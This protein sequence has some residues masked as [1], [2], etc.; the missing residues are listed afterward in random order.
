[1]N[2]DIAFIKRCIEL[3][4]ISI[5]SGDAPFGSLITRNGILVAEGTNDV[6]T[7]ISEHAEVT[8]LHNAHQ[9]LGTSNLSDCTLYSNCEPCPMCSFMI[10]EYKVKRV[11]YAMQSK[12]M[13]GFSKWPIL[14]DIELTEIQPFF[15]SPPIVEGGI[16]EK[17]AH[18]V[19][20]GTIFWQ[21]VDKKNL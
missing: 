1:M 3:S 7:K 11:V 18:E 4:Q 10:R 17:E 14:Q 15:G 6:N 13:G 21:I 9:V 16:L 8:A 20:R 19:M 5:D 12:Y 2:K